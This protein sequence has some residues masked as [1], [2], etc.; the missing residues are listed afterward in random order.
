[1]NNKFQLIITSLIS[2]SIG[3]LASS[4]FSPEAR[5]QKI[6]QDTA[7]EVGDQKSLSESENSKN[8]KNQ[9]VNIAL[10]EAKN[11][12]V[13]EKSTI[14][15]KD[16][17]VLS[18]QLKEFEQKTD[19]EIEKKYATLNLKEKT[20]ELIKNDLN[21]RLEYMFQY[22]KTWFTATLSNPDNEN[23]KFVFYT[24][25]YSCD[26]KPTPQNQMHKQDNNYQNYCFIMW[27]YSF[28]QNKWDYTS[29]S[30]T[31]EFP[32]WKDDDQYLSYNVED[33]GDLSKETG[34]LRIMVPM[35]NRGRDTQFLK[36]ING[37]YEWVDGDKIGWIESSESEAKK[38][39]DKTII[40]KY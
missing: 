18:K 7:R 1:M 28:Y 37:K 9:N 10:T 24:H 32:K 15:P 40:N 19:S 39:K 16:Y 38:F 34:L 31:M 13:V 6:T 5:D 30:S 25:F 23:D 35:L 29:M 20:N 3:I 27:C 11:E 17:F 4:Y 36:L 14:T 22:K 26:S 2:F 8:P 33:L 12:I 21:N